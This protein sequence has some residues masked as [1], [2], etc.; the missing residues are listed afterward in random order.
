MSRTRTMTVDAGAFKATLLILSEASMDL[1]EAAWPALAASMAVVEKHAR[2]VLS[3][4]DHTLKDLAK[5]DHP[6]ARRHP[7]IMI[8][9]SD[10]WRVHT[11][12]GALLRALLNTA[13]DAQQGP[14]HVV[15]LDQ[16][17]TE[18]VKYVVEGTKYMHPR[19][20]LWAGTALQPKVQQAAL[21]ALVRVLGKELRSK[22]GVRVHAG[23]GARTSGMAV[24]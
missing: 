24:G 12:T 10:P 5:R 23:A 16:T 18:H 19:D 21:T 6:Y 3:A 17:V 8:H 1:E 15:Y 7:R 4:T 11:H 22:L 2:K 9:K 20:P 13:Y 14:A